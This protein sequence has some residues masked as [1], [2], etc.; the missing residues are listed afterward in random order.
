[1]GVSAV[2]PAPRTRPRP[3]VRFVTL[4][5]LSLAALL[6]TSGLAGHAI[7]NA[8]HSHAAVQA[9]LLRQEAMA[10]DR[11]AELT[12]SRHFAAELQ[13]ALRKVNGEQA[14]VREALRLGS[15]RLHSAGHRVADAERKLNATRV[16]LRSVSA[17]WRDCLHSAQPQ[18]QQL[19][20][21]QQQQQ[22]QHRQQ[23][24]QHPAAHAGAAGGVSA[25][26][27]LSLPPP[28]RA[29]SPPDAGVVGSLE[30]E[31]AVLRSLVGSV[32][33]QLGDELRSARDDAAAAA[34]RAA[35]AEGRVRESEADRTRLLQFVAQLRS[36]LDGGPLAAGGAAAGGATAP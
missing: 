18:M 5:L 13:H 22:Q 31:V 9:E 25:R 35:A 11:L 10:A 19:E 1:M 20:Q 33:R 24:Q 34:A 17:A 26:A 28:P 3:H 30:R 16:E 21:Q 15:E 6:L 8:S 27:L 23:Q 2:L 29:A 7:S 4:S 14:A 12:A 36:Q 32:R